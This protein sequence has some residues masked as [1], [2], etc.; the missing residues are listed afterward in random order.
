MYAFR[1][2]ISEI[3]MCSFARLYNKLQ[4]QD[5]PVGYVCL[6]VC[7]SVCVCVSADISLNCAK[8]D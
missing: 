4:L 8:N 7:L 5:L 1:L 2:N 3:C 6:C